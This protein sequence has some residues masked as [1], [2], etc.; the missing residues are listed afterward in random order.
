MSNPGVESGRAILKTLIPSEDMIDNSII[1]TAKLIVSIVEA[2]RDLGVGRDVG[3]SAYM[4]AAAAQTSL[5]TARDHMISCHRELVEV[6]D[7][8]GI[9]PMSVGCNTACLDPERKT[10]GLSVVAPA[11]AA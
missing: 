5:A 4:Q 6:R 8:L 10:S 9:S 7:T 1:Q 3:H 11:A 2:R